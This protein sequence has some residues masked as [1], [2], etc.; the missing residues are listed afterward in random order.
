MD[1]QHRATVGVDDGAPV[2]LVILG[3]HFDIPNPHLANAINRQLGA[4]D[5]QQRTGAFARV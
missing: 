2:A 4:N 5:V 3:H 1:V